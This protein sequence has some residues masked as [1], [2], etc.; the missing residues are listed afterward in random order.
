MAE[1]R[2]I[3]YGRMVYETLRNYYSVNY[4]GDISFVFKFVAACIAPLINPFSDYDT[5]RQKES[6]IANCKWVIGQLTNVLNYLYDSEL[7][8]IYITQS[9]VSNVNDPQFEY[10]PVNFDKVF[11]EV[12]TIYERLFN[13]QANVSIVTINI[14][15]SVNQAELIATIEQIKVKGIPYQIN[16]I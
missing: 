5:Y 15:S 10:P 9:T 6:L 8:R 7:N 13:D 11:E 3:D 1:F 14:P 12:P 16:V 4:D 2:N